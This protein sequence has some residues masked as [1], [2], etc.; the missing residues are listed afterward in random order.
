MF[1]GVGD[2]KPPKLIFT[3]PPT[4]IVWLSYPGEVDVIEIGPNIE[5]GFT[6]RLGITVTRSKDW[7]LLIEVVELNT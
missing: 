5:A 6:L 3:H 4:G 7:L 2:N 1:Y